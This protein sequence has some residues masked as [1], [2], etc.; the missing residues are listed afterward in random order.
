MTD[1]N[2]GKGVRLRIHVM[3]N[4]WVLYI[5]LIVLHHMCRYLRWIRVTSMHAETFPSSLSYPS[6]L[7]QRRSLAFAQSSVMVLSPSS[8]ILPVPAI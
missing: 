4:I 1:G 2:Q 7:F 3:V 5:L 8:G 6:E